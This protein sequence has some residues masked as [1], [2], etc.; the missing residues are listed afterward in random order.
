MQIWGSAEVLKT[1]GA[2][3]IRASVPSSPLAGG[4]VQHH[5]EHSS[6]AFKR[7]FELP[8]RSQ[9]HG[10]QTQ[11]S[12]QTPPLN[13]KGREGEGYKRVAG[14]FEAFFTPTCLS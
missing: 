11:G 4:R 2:L 8:F 1:L 10:T 7:F 6:E 3:R 13:L 12:R 14:G 5:P 9:S